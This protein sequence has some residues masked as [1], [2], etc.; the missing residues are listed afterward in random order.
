[1][2]VKKIGL[3]INPYAGLGGKVGLKGTDGIEILNKALSMGAIPLS[4][5][6]AKMALEN[7]RNKHCIH[8]YTASGNMG[9]DICK[10]LKIRY[11][12]I[13]SPEISFTHTEDTKSTA[14]KLLDQQ[15]DLIL[16]AGGDGTAKDIQTIIKDRIPIVG[17]PC[18]VKM[19]SGVFAINLKQV[20]MMINTFIQSE[21]IN[22]K[23]AE[24]LDI[25]E[26][27]LRAGYPATQLFGYAKTIATAI[28]QSAKGNK[29]STNEDMLDAICYEN[30]KFL[31]ETDI[32]NIIG[33]GSTM[34]K[35][36]IMPMSMV[37]Y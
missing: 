16:F 8:F 20:N 37:H 22:Y 14:Q 24:I 3:I 9:E 12:V 7:L 21:N 11:Q 35:S 31:F 29:K 6:R 36:P 33:P 28:I 32:I 19:Y 18:G 1:M 13:Y 5:I 26:T 23:E 10:E 15:V 2:K 25:D 34:K 30:A 27:Y 17:I 4:N